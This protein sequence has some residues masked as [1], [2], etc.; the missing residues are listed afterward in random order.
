MLPGESV[1]IDEKIGMPSAQSTSPKAGAQHSAPRTPVTD[2]LAHMDAL[3][4]SYDE[5]ARY[6]R[7]MEREKEDH[8]SSS[9]T[10]FVISIE[11]RKYFIM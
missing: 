10:L 7:V 1:G 11:Q 4:Y 5:S 2:G 9:R 6:E 8:S 3:Y